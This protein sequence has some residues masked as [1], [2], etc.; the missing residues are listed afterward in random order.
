MCSGSLF[1]IAS[2]NRRVRS[3]SS[4]RVSAL[5]AGLAFAQAFRAATFATF[6]GYTDHHVSNGS[7]SRKTISVL[8]P[9][10]MTRLSAA[11]FARSGVECCGWSRGM[12]HPGTAT[13]AGQETRVIRSVDRWPSSRNCGVRIISP[14]ASSTNSQSSTERGVMPAS[15][16]RVL[17]LGKHVHSSLL[18]RSA[19]CTSSHRAEGF[20]SG[21]NSI[22]LMTQLTAA[23]LTHPPCGR[24]RTWVA[25]SLALAP[26]GRCLAG[27]GA[28]TP[29][30][31]PTPAAICTKTATIDMPLL[32]ASTVWLEL[33]PG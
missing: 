27:R 18:A 8:F 19:I 9:G 14:A 20:T 4:A 6:R 10:S 17:W 2:A 21:G 29:P 33:S 15:F 7:G 28:P 16:A 1:T 13:V 24:A 30:R 12:L 5:I 26:L 11:T 23:W 25:K 22:S 32:R 3:I 31:R